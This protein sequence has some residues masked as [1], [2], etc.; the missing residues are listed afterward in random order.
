MCLNPYDGN[1]DN[2]GEGVHAPCA[3]VAARGWDTSADVVEGGHQGVEEP[4]EEGSD[5]SH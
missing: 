4:D 1:H 2:P 5:L 3:A